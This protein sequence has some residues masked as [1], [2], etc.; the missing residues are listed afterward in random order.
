MPRRVGEGKSLR[1]SVPEGTRVGELVAGVLQD[2]RV[3]LVC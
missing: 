2:L 1:L 3:C